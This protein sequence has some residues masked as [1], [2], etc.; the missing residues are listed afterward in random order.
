MFREGAPGLYDTN[1]NLNTLSIQTPILKKNSKSKRVLN[2]IRTPKLA[3]IL[4][5]FLGGLL[6]D[7]RILSLF[8]C[9]IIDRCMLNVYSLCTALHIQAIFSYHGNSLF[10]IKMSRFLDC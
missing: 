5:V 2:F 3:Q 1:S 8:L 10:R 6:L 7:H 4:V 9:E